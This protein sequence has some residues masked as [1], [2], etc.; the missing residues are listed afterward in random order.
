MEPRTEPR[1]P[2][3]PKRPNTAKWIQQLEDDEE[4]ARIATLEEDEKIAKKLQQ[5]YENGNAID[6]FHRPR[7]ARNPRHENEISMSDSFLNSGELDETPS[8]NV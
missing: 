7:T 5:D 2:N 3:E 1:I 6:D 8:A 4:L